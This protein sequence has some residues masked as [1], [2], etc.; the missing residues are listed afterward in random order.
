DQAVGPLLVQ[1]GHPQQDLGPLVRLLLRDRSGRPAAGLARQGTR[2]CATWLAAHREAVSAA[3]M[4]GDT[5]QASSRPLRN[6][7]ISVAVRRASASTR[8]SPR[9]WALR[10][11]PAIRSMVSW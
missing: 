1:L 5:S 10:S 9:S 6:A 11:V 2:S 4:S 8:I 3:G 7:S